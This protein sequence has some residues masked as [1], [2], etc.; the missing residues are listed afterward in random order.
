M[1]RTN[2]VTNSCKVLFV[3]LF[4][5]TD[6]KENREKN[7]KR[8]FLSHSSV[9]LCLYFFLYFFFQL[10]QCSIFGTLCQTISNHHFILN[11]MLFFNDDSELTFHLVIQLDFYEIK[12]IQA[13]CSK[14]FLHMVASTFFFAFK[15]EKKIL[16]YI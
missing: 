16:K 6:T 8:R 5:K 1:S 14:A 3:S 10:Q 9:S 11:S 2:L 12:K 15:R 7:N 4:L 13:L